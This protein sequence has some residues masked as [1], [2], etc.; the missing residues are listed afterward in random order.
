MAQ[1]AGV[2]MQHGQTPLHIAASKD[3]AGVAQLLLDKGASVDEID[4]VCNMYKGYAHLPHA[5]D[6]S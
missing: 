2:R 4:K 1:D 6:T 3:S 5:F